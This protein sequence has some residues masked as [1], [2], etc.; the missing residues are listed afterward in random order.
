MGN[1]YYSAR[2]QGFTKSNQS[3]D[4]I[5]NFFLLGREE[6]VHKSMLVSEQI[7]TH[8]K[9]PQNT[10][11]QASFWQCVDWSWTVVSHL[12][13][14]RKQQQE[15]KL[16][17]TLW[18]MQPQLVLLYTA[19]GTAPTRRINSTCKIL[20]PCHKLRGQATADSSTWK[21]L[22]FQHPNLP[23]QVPRCNKQADLHTVF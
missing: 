13:W 23:P 8:K 1:F 6:A 5:S 3:L 22:K 17:L 4:Q 2:T 21:N 20:K 19:L 10:N 11:K 12:A 14:W 7:C 18:H 15:P 9:S 16:E